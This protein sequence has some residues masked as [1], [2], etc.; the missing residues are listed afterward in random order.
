MSP[1]VA[2]GVLD[3]VPPIASDSRFERFEAVTSIDWSPRNS[4][5]SR[6]R[7]IAGP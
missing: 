7:R 2:P 1:G 3:G 5:G 4:L 6:V